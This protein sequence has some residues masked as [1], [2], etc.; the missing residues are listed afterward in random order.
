MIVG[1]CLVGFVVREVL[2]VDVSGSVGEEK[3]DRE[4][5]VENGHAF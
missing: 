2:S 5:E 3:K 1:D 4:V